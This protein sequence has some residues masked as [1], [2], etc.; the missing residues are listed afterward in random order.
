M[1]AEW[2]LSLGSRGGQRAARGE[3]LR[4]EEHECAPWTGTT[5]IGPKHFVRC[6]SW[7]DR[8]YP[9]PVE[10]GEVQLANSLVLV[11]RALANFRRPAASAAPVLK[12]RTRK[13]KAK[14]SPK[15]GPLW[16]HPKAQV[17]TFR[18][19][20][21][22]SVRPWR[23]LAHDAVI[24][25]AAGQPGF[26][27][28][29]ER[30]CP[31]FNYH[32]AA[33]EYKISNERVI[34]R[35]HSGAIILSFMNYNERVWLWRDEARDI[36]PGTRLPHYVMRSRDDGKSW[37]DVTMLHQEWTGEIRNII[38]TPQRPPHHFLHENAQ[39]PRASSTVLTYSSD[40]DGA[41][42][43]APSNLID[44]GGRGHHGG[45]TERSDDR[46]TGRRAGLDAPAQ[47]NWSK[48]WQAFS[49]DDG[50]TWRGTSAP[51]PSTPAGRCPRAAQA[52]RPAAA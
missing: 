33:K 7:V 42:T 45:V 34:F 26:R 11:I 51:A 31:L 23:R 10:T 43:W 9:H 21:P 4:R 38:Q 18:Q 25:G 52:A 20:G 46:T 8:A 17:L 49:E 40:D 15:P 13:P 16:L 19:I 29:L 48:F 36:L 5:E 2:E 50:R 12:R 3:A 28:D 14:T 27:A 41:P 1:G 47:A 22:F 30:S 35:T 44:L 6:S 39:Q 37:Q 32:E 24:P